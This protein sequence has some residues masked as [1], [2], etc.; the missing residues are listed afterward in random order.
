MAVSTGKNEDGT[1]N[2]TESHQGVESILRLIRV[3]DSVCERHALFE[4]Q[5]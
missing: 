1:L 5:T 3:R 2:L 4:C